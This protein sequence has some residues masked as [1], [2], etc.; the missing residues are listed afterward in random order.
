MGPG[1][2]SGSVHFPEASGPGG[3]RLKPAPRLQG[4]LQGLAACSPCAPLGSLLWLLGKKQL[5]SGTP[6][7]QS[8]WNRVPS[9]GFGIQPR[10]AEVRLG[11]LTERQLSIEQ[12]PAEQGP[13]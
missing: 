5:A 3:Y 11:T 7:P 12:S 8:L 2:Q 13:R 10:S 6:G 4:P 9:V 1:T